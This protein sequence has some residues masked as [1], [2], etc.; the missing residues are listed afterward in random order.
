MTNKQIA[1]R[2][3]APVVVG[4]AIA[5]GAM[6]A[7]H[8]NSNFFWMFKALLGLSTQGALKTLTVGTTL[9]SLISLPAVVLAAFLI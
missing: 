5:S 6:F 8:V 7:V 1:E 9:G 2:G 3:V 4:L